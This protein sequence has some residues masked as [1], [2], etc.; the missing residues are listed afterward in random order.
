MQRAAE[1]LGLSISLDRHAAED[2]LLAIIVAGLRNEHLKGPYL[3]AAHR[4]HVTRAMD[5]AIVSA[6]VGGGRSVGVATASHSNLAPTC[7]VRRW[8]VSIV[9]R[10][11]T[12]KKVP[13]KARARR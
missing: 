13:N 11:P 4:A 7:N 2:D 6:S 3:I 10:S 8:M 9:G 12:G 5:S 1:L